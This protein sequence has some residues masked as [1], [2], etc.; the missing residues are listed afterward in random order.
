M[1][2]VLQKLEQAI[3]AGELD[4]QIQVASELLRAKFKK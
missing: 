4:S 3:T 1:I 2:D